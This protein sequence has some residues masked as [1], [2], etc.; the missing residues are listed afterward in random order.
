[1]AHFTLTPQ[2]REA[3]L[4]RGCDVAVTAGAGSGKT[5]TLVARYACLLADGLPMRSIVA[6]TFTEKA[7]LEMRAR[8]RQTLVK[9]V[10]SALD[11]SE[12]H[13]WAGLNAGIDSARI[14]TIHSLC[15]EIL[16]AHPVEARVDPR[17]EVI[18]EGI[19]AALKAAILEDTLAELVSR[20]EYVT[21]FSTL[22][23]RGA[24]NSA[25]IP[26]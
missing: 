10:E 13:F 4:A 21:L 14:S 9:L 7:A 22:G 16:R 19:E 2:Q 6:I 23:S 18:D 12:R 3:A 11:N 1:M 17:F 5:S 24:E 8:V 25:G 20:A 15:T 26:A